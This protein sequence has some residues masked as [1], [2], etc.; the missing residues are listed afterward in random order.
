MSVFP[1]SFLATTITVF[2]PVS[3][4]YK[5]SFKYGGK[6]A[7]DVGL[8]CRCH[9]SN[10]MPDTIFYDSMGWGMTQLLL[11]FFYVFV[12]FLGVVIPVF[13]SIEEMRYEF[14]IINIIPA[15]MRKS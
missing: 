1:E 3:C 5:T 2:T 14:S 6:K 15:G 8:T 7:G 10:I 12:F 4:Y 9:L 13:L 11:L